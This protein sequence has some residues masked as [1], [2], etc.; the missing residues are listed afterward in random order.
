VLLGWAPAVLVG[1]AQAAVLLALVGLAGLPVHSPFGLV[2]FT[3]LA[4][5]AFAATNQALVSV[6]GSIG[7]LVSL[8]F[9]MLEAAALGGLIPVQTAPQLLQ[10]LNG[11]LPLPRFVDGASQLFLGGSS[12]DLGGAVVVLAVWTVGALL[13]SVLA[14]SRQRPRLST[15]P[16]LVPPA[17]A[18][19]PAG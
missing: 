11:V 14:T 17:L 6:F 4:V 7:R 5:L 18:V 13:V 15:T 9:T 16:T 2:A 12:G 3:G 19:R 1:A 8:A 10:L